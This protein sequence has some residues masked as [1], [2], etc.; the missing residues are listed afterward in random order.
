[1]LHDRFKLLA[2]LLGKSFRKGSLGY[3]F[4]F[5]FADPRQERTV[6]DQVEAARAVLALFKDRMPKGFI[7]GCGGQGCCLRLHV[8]G[9]C[10]HLCIRC[11]AC[12]RLHTCLR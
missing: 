12:A 6:A 4:K 2:L 11:L 3:D 1:M 9:C 8:L 10:L 5:R 7:L